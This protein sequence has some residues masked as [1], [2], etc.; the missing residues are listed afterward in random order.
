MCVMISV[1]STSDV[2]SYPPRLTMI[3]LLN[4]PKWFMLN[5]VRW[6][7]PK[8]WTCSFWRG[9]T[10]IFLTNP[11][12]GKS[13]TIKESERN[14]WLTPKDS[15]TMNSNPSKRWFSTGSIPLYAPPRWSRWS[16]LYFAPI[17]IVAKDG[18]PKRP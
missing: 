3:S 17:S 8:L 6:F 16:T 13:A 11:N 18:S 14:G 1:S 12:P 10:I 5:S 15:W 9:T 4:K 7:L 2:V